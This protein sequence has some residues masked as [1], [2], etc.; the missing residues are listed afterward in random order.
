MRAN[1]ISKILLMI[2]LYGRKYSFVNISPEI[3]C[4]S[5]VTVK[6]IKATFLMFFIVFNESVVIV[7]I[8]I[9]RF[10]LYYN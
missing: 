5:P 8:S 6:N 4:V 7:S 10:V 3:M 1:G 2:R 9:K